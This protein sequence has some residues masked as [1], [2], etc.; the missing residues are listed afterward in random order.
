[1]STQTNTHTTA[2]SAQEQNLSLSE[3]EKLWAA[4]DAVK[5]ELADFKAEIYPYFEK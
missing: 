2:Q 3:A 1:M 4:L 5:K